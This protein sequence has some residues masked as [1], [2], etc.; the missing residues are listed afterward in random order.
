MLHTS[1]FDIWFPIIWCSRHGFLPTQK[2]KNA[3]VSP[4]VKQHNPTKIQ[5][6]FTNKTIKLEMGPVQGDD[7]PRGA[8]GPRV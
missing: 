3:A 4:L 2:M 6:N 1:V 8:H 7:G 5:L